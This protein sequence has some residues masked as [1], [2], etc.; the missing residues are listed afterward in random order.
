M[1]VIMINLTEEQIDGDY[2]MPI[3]EWLEL[4]TGNRNE[5]MD[6]HSGI[7]SDGFRLHINL[8]NDSA[9]ECCDEEIHKKIDFVL[10]KAQHESKFVFALSRTLLMEA[11]SGINSSDDN[12]LVFFHDGNT[13]HPVVIRDNGKNRAAIIMPLDMSSFDTT[14]KF[15][16]CGKDE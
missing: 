4:A 6:P 2:Q 16:K 15:P 1:P 9:C 13:S 11:L 14:L 5:L 10:D 8:N 12:M 3:K 7:A